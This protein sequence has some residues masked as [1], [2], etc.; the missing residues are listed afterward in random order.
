MYADYFREKNPN[1]DFR[2]IGALLATGSTGLMKVYGDYMEV[3]G[4]NSILMIV[5]SK[6]IDIKTF[7][8]SVSYQVGRLYNSQQEL[9]N[10]RNGNNDTFDQDFVHIDFEDNWAAHTFNVCWTLAW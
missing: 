8:T 6:K 3:H 10:R 7:L 1:L 5:D 9:E 4:S 2:A